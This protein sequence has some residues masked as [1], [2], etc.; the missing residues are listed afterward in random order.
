MAYRKLST[1]SDGTKINRK[2]GMGGRNLS[3]QTLSWNYGLPCENRACKSYGK[4]HPNCRCHSGGPEGLAKGGQ[5]C[6]QNM[7]H[8]PS[9]EFYKEGGE[10]APYQPA[11]PSIALGHAAMDQGA[12]GIL[13]DVGQVNI[14]D[15]DSH[16]KTLKKAK[17]HLSMNN[18]DKAKDVLR[19]TPMTGQTSQANMTHVLEH[20]APSI[21]AN[22]V[23]PT[24]FRASNDYLNSALKGH[25]SV[26]NESSTLFGDQK[27]ADRPRADE[28]S[29]DQLK[30]FLSES[31]TNPEALLD[32][33]SNIGH[34]LPDHAVE[35]GAFA[36]RATSYLNSLKPM[37][38]QAS[39]MDK[40]LSPS[41][42]AEGAWNRQ[43]DIAQNP[44]LVYQHVKDG[45][46]LPQDITTIQTLYPALYKSMVDEAGE[47]LINAKTK[48]DKI[49]YKQRAS[50]SRLMGV[51]LSS[52]M[53][54]Q[55]MQ[56][57]IKANS[58]SES[59]QS[60][61][62]GKSDKATAV[63]LKAISQADKLYETPLE[64][65]QIDKKS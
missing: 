65:R 24:A 38:A 23:N 5:V 25:Q 61:E 29:R 62:G 3:P 26:K 19:G 59:P 21:I 8:L 48:G 60:Q 15:P 47:S 6:A 18:H 53:T 11:H 35:I 28:V 14:A 64:S 27:R 55:A 36:S 37:G 43:L 22:D 42:M 32:V 50:L 52:T 1:T 13:K 7:P 12:H 34:Y 49:P 2:P 16:E 41:K 45:T 9:C 57:I 63:E 39:P 33:A 44:K 40:P 51:P 17:D 56:A 58:S 46:L 4:P 20:L 30:E 10:V 31:Q 54:P